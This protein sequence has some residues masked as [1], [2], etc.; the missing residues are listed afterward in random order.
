[1]Q[2]PKSELRSKPSQ[3][4][5]QGSRKHTGKQENKDNTAARATN[6]SECKN[7]HHPAHG[8]SIPSA[9]RSRRS[10]HH[11]CL[12]AAAGLQ[13]QSMKSFKL[14]EPYLLRFLQQSR[15]GWWS[16][17]RDPV[18]VLPVWRPLQHHWDMHGVFHPRP[19][20]VLSW[21]FCWFSLLLLCLIHSD[22]RHL[23]HTDIKSIHTTASVH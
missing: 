22:D 3:S 15:A 1:M 5:A 18:L 16:P 6:A 20:H 8:E 21:S 10:A 19:L 11:A 17:Q 14:K 7:I 13:K 4:T 23:C 2:C 12:Q 9:P